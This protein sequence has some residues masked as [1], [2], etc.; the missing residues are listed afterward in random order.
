[1]LCA[2]YVIPQKD[3]TNC[4]KLIDEKNQLF[5]YPSDRDLKPNHLD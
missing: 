5:C 4:A 1:M 2:Q 3:R